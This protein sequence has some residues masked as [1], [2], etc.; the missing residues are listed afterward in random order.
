MLLLII[1][2]TQKLT[3]TR[4]YDSERQSCHYRIDCSFYY[5]HLEFIRNTIGVN[6]CLLIKEK[7]VETESAF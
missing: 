3:D 2:Q 6:K 4:I 7:Y 5:M 1:V